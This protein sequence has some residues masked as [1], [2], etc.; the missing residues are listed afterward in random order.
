MYAL[1][2]EVTSFPGRTF[3]HE[4]NKANA[5]PNLK[6]CMPHAIRTLPYYVCPQSMVDLNQWQQV[7]SKHK[8]SLF[9]MKA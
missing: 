6:T 3:Y 9:N 1:G 7:E 2:S 8:A 4:F 5:F